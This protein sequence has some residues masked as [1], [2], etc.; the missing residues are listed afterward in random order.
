MKASVSCQQLFLI[1]LIYLLLW[2]SSKPYFLAEARNKVVV[3]HNKNAQRNCLQ[4]KLQLNYNAYEGIH[5]WKYRTCFHCKLYVRKL[6]GILSE[7]LL[8][9]CRTGQSCIFCWW[10]PN[11]KRIKNSFK[12]QLA[13]GVVTLEG[14]LPPEWY[15]PVPVTWIS[16]VRKQFNILKANPKALCFHWQFPWT[17]QWKNGSCCSSWRP[18]EWRRAALGDVLLCKMHF[19]FCPIN[20]AQLNSLNQYP[21][22]ELT[23]LFFSEFFGIPLKQL[24]A[25]SFWCLLTAL[26]WLFLIWAH[27]TQHGG[28]I[29]YI[30]FLRSSLIWKSILLHTTNN[31]SEAVYGQFNLIS[32]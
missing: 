17:H 11:L 30:L 28:H 24:W 25:K 27:F 26:R 9:S 5:I 8:R 18:E 23:Y 20:L 3:A 21:A 1:D 6:R 16:Q 10:L 14:H 29:L 13:G 19:P 4:G 22:R 15:S 31:L 12:I 7:W 2:Y 32:P